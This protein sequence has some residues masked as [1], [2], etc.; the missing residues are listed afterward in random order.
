VP[1][2]ESDR[3]RHER[4]GDDQ[5]GPHQRLHDREGAAADLV[6]HL[7][8]QQREPGEVGDAG[9][10]PHEDDEQQ[11][12]PQREGPR[13]EQDHDAGADDADPEDALA[14]E[15]AGDARAERDTGAEAHEHGAEEQTVGGVTAA[16][17]V[18]ERL[19]RRDDH[20]RRGH[21]SGD[22]DHEAPHQRRVAGEGEAVLQGAQERLGGLHRAVGASAADRREVPDDHRGDEEGQRVQV[23]REVHLVDAGDHVGDPSAHGR[24]DREDDRREHGGEAVGGDER[25]LVGRLQ[26]VLAQH[27]RDRGLLGGDPEQREGLDEELGH[28]QPDQVV[29]QRDRR[30]QG[31]PDDVDDH[32]RLAAVEPVGEGAGERAQDD[33]REEP[34][35]QHTAEGEVRRREPVDERRRR[36]GDREKPEPVTEA[37]QRHRQPQLAEVGHPEHRAELRD[38]AYRARHVGPDTTLTDRSGR[39]R[40]RRG[41]W[42]AVRHR[43]NR[44]RGHRGTGR[45]QAVGRWAGLLHRLR[46]RRPLG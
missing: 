39:G 34:E 30:E 9:E 4:E 12:D 20:A 32:H 23:E 46:L 14:R 37:R 8:A 36:R 1:S 24:E 35:E 5:R 3:E 29:D 15:V 28:E 18:G 27:V 21:R 13:H 45:W 38:Q 44:I 42:P 10:E 25:E 33:C 16:E 7:G 22:T 43:R 11:R 17:R 41:Q 31:E 19:A 2:D 26:L 6:L 40:R